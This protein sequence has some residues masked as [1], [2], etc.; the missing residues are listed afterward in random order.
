[1][2]GPD[3][4]YTSDLRRVEHLTDTQVAVLAAVERLGE[5]TLSRLYTELRAMNVLRV[6]DEVAGLEQLGLVR[7]AK[8][9]RFSRLEDAR[10]MPTPVR[11]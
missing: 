2:G 6:A 3:K 8:H 1:M 11:R 4:R 5:A 10:W 7:R 9:S